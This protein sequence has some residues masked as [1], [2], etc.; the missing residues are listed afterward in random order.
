MRMMSENLP[1]CIV[2]Y[3]VLEKN[4][5]KWSEKKNESNGIF[6][7]LGLIAC[8]TSVFLSNV[9]MSYAT[10]AMSQFQLLALTTEV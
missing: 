10:F 2:T 1:Q 5:K 8:H 9:T 6:N 3:I 4:V 7:T